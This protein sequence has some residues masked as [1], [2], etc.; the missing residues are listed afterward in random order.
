MPTEP[1]HSS[2]EM[3]L[4]PMRCASYLI[5]VYLTGT[6]HLAKLANHQ[7]PL[8]RIQHQESSHLASSLFD[9]CRISST[10][11]PF[12][13]KTK[14]ICTG[15]EYALASLF[16]RA[17]VK[18]AD[19][20]PAKAKPSKP[21]QSQSDPRFSL[22]RGAQ[23]QNKPKQTQNKP[24][25][26]RRSLLATAKPSTKPGSRSRIK[27]GTTAAR[28]HPRPRQ[29][30]ECPLVTN[31]FDTKEIADSESVTPVRCT[32]KIEKLALDGRRQMGSICAQI[33]ARESRKAVT[34]LNGTVECYMRRSKGNLSAGAF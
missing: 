16:T 10:N 19:F 23:S 11:S 18:N 24:N 5:G 27:P 4:Y 9:F 22:T 30:Q 2:H 8:T 15:P 14:P 28:M 21:K 3:T 13:C 1:Q 25:L 12:S 31:Y 34:A 17:Y 20:S 7:L 33:L 6:A 26:S 29:L 32:R